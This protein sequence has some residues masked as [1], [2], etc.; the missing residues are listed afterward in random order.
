VS[1]LL[2]RL[3]R[4][5]AWLTEPC[6]KCQAQVPLGLIAA[7][8]EVYDSDPISALLGVAFEDQID[9]ETAWVGLGRGGGLVE[10]AV[11]GT[12]RRPR[13]TPMPTPKTW[14][15]PKAGSR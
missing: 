3:F 2:R 4:R 8:R 6:S 14:R 7:R 13:Y 1:D 12:T 10:C 15:P 9:S 11:C 5:P